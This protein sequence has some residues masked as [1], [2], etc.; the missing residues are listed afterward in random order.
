MDCF[1]NL[2]RLSEIRHHGGRRN[3]KPA[4]M[5]KGNKCDLFALNLPFTNK[6][7]ASL[8]SVIHLR[9]NVAA[10]CPPVPRCPHHKETRRTCQ[11]DFSPKD[12]PAAIC[13]H[14]W[15][16]FAST[17]RG[18]T[19]HVVRK[20]E[21]VES[22]A[23]VRKVRETIF[24]PFDS[25]YL[26]QMF[27]KGGTIRTQ[28]MPQETTWV[29]FPIVL[30]SHSGN[31]CSNFFLRSGYKL[32]DGAPSAKFVHVLRDD[33]KA[34]SFVVRTEKWCVDKVPVVV[35][36]WNAGLSFVPALA[37]LRTSLVQ[38]KALFRCIHKPKRSVTVGVCGFSGHLCFLRATSIMRQK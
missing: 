20:R 10:E 11:L 35:G 2:N 7:K 33:K 38:R 22:P 6:G 18:R 3:T 19:L 28:A 29:F 24:K 17:S 12:V 34:C 27:R 8:G 15:R 32:V 9:K 4:W 23:D 36:F 5:R 37:G 13:P 16:G 14:L 25:R 31:S 1:K 21:V 26:P 30:E